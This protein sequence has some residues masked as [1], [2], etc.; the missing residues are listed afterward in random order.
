M[1][2]NQATGRDNQR[3]ERGRRMIRRANDFLLTLHDASMHLS[4]EAFQHWTLTELRKYLDFDF[5]MWGAGNGY[6]RNLHAAT[7][8][9]QSDNLFSTW[10][11]VKEID[12]YAHLV[13]GNTGRTWALSQVP[14]IYESRAYNEHWRLYQARQMISTMQIDPHTGLHVF[15]TLARDRQQFDFNHKEAAFKN[16]VCEHLFL[17]ARHNDQHYLSG[18]RAPAALVDMRGLLH[19][20]L[21]DFRA[22]TTSEWGN[23]ANHR[24]PGAVTRSLWQTGHY[25]GS[26]IT[27]V[28]R[29]L[30]NRLL[31]RAQPTVLTPLSP[32][33]I[34]VASRYAAGASH[35]EVAKL[36][37]VSPT[38]VRTHLTRIYRKLEVRDKGALALRI[39]EHKEIERLL[40]PD[41]E[42]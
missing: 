5:A 16:L 22:L 27:L 14:D 1:V 28:T 26:R 42:P 31:V 9:D 6:H 12:P 39:K 24:L 38:T 13:I 11:P 29:R 20:A 10:E 36:L 37:G 34:E 41:G 25:Q 40:S 8:L 18:I 33:E 30:G 2:G 4:P 17:A 32:R 15:V 35:K 21:P 7:V 3:E 19:A 23:G